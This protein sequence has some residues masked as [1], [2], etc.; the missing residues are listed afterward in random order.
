MFLLNVFKTISRKFNFLRKVVPYVCEEFGDSSSTLP[1]LST[2]MPIPS[3]LCHTKSYIAVP[4]EP[5]THFALLTAESKGLPLDTFVLFTES[6]NI[7][8]E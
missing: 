4:G 1:A 5:K 2:T 6:D 7:I 8:Y 3:R